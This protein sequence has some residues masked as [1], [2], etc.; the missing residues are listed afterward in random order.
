MNQLPLDSAAAAAENA[1][2][3]IALLDS[4][5]SESRV[6]VAMA[7]AMAAQHIQW[8]ASAELF[9]AIDVTLREA[10]VHPEIFLGAPRVGER[11]GAHVEAH[12]GAQTRER[13][14]AQSG[15]RTGMFSLR[16]DTE[17]A[18]RA[19]TADLAVR[20][21]LAELI[22]RHH[23]MIAHTLQERI[24]H[25]WALFT[26]GGVSTQNARE[27][28]SIV[29][30]LPTELWAEFETHVL[31]AATRAP[32]RFRARARAISERLRAHTL[33][34]RHA[35][36]R[37]R[38]GVWTEI[39][40]DGMG[41]LNAH[42]PAETLARVNANLDGIA[43]SLF[44]GTAPTAK[45]A[46]E[47]RTM[48]QL[49]ADVLS[50]LLTGKSHGNVGAASCTCDGY[51]EA[52]GGRTGKVGT[53][54]VG[55]SSSDQSSSDRSGTDSACA[56]AGTCACARAARIRPS[57]GVTV[58]LTIPVLTLLGHSNDPALLEG[59]GPIDIAAARKLCATATSITRLLTDPISG[60]ILQMDP[61]QYRVPAALKRW[62]AI[63]QVTCDF[64]GCGRRAANCDLDHTRAWAD[65][66]S[67]TA[68]NLT[69][70]CRNHHTLKHRTKWQV[71]KPPGAQRATWTSPTGY[72][73][74]ADSPPF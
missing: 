40:R 4:V 3:A 21:S 5:D 2:P 46:A 59:V 17:Y 53:G 63:E 12:S 62:L 18:E 49:R 58:A 22:V 30:E 13:A 42:L 65:G 70:R 27:A 6:G 25:L 61:H 39:D 16:E 52:G 51:D 41:W 71:D 44:K 26:A 36:A 15:A 24:P 43:F 60:T 72:R 47:T 34:E 57:V 8:R 19:A 54:S 67:T 31:A 45:A 73:Q 66:G 50:D 11:V 9:R 35:A 68:A 74:D 33:T 7:E 28:A 29:S 37:L 69:H 20:L 48:A 1:A 23:G 10:V 32:A 55:Q 56:P 14:G 64:P 38:R